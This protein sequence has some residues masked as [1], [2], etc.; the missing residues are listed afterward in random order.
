MRFPEDEH[1][2]HLEIYRL[3]DTLAVQVL[4]LFLISDAYTAA[5]NSLDI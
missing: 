1:S 3:P 5:P 4:A 2:L